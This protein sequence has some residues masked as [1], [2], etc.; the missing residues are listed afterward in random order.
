MFDGKR[1][2]RI[3][4]PYVSSLIVLLEDY[5]KALIS[6][7]R[8]NIPVSE[9]KLKHWYPNRNT[10]SSMHHGTILFWVRTDKEKTEEEREK[11]REKG[12]KGEEE[13]ERV[14]GG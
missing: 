13:R 5:I 7:S 9:S 6:R 2:C 4:L 1:W 11:K 3:I 10:G 8:F 14:F 12:R